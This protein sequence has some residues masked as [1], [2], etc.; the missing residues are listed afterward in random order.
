M[1]GEHHAH[2]NE[3]S[4]D[5]LDGLFQL[6]PN[7]SQHP[8][9]YP[10]FCMLGALKAQG[11]RETLLSQLQHFLVRCGG[12]VV[13]PREHK[14]AWLEQDLGGK[15]LDGVAEET[16]LNKPHD[17]QSVLG[18][19][20]QPQAPAMGYHQPSPQCNNACSLEKLLY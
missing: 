20:N 14:E 11:I 7:L 3:V 16:K 10:W 4:H 2:L 6:A 19:S 8:V 1:R 17:K 18:T 13:H 15:G 5:F 12:P 9:V